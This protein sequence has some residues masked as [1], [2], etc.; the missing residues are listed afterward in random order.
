VRRFSESELELIWDRRSEGVGM[1]TVA[2]DLGRAHASVR[3]M[4][5]SYGGVR[6]RT[7][8]RSPRHLSLEEREEISRGMAS[9]ESLRSIARRLG[10]SASTVSREVA[11]NGRSGYRAHRADQAALRR[12]RRPKACKLAT[13]PKLALMVEE[14]LGLWWSPQQISG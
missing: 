6:P 14:K 1:R 7:Q 4:V 11:R 9:G 13:N 3:S 5:E 12:V 2:R 10:R 8:I